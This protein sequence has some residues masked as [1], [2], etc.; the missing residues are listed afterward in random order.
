[1]SVSVNWRFKFS[2]HIMDFTPVEPWLFFKPNIFLHVKLRF[3]RNVPPS[4]AK[5]KTGSITT[6][7]LLNLEHTS[8]NWT[9]PCILY[10]YYY[11][12]IRK[13]FFHRQLDFLNSFHIMWPNPTQCRIVFLQWTSK[14]TSFYCILVLLLI[15]IISIIRKIVFYWKLIH[16]T[17]YHYTGQT[18]NTLELILFIH[19]NENWH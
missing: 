13:R 2:H 5:C 14:H 7:H 19:I 8:L 17:Y 15:Y 1:M 12:F 9:Q 6:L 16:T 4:A 10:E 18:R 11:L 3:K